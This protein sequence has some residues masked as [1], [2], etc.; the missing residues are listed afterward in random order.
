MGRA[1]E[2]GEAMERLLA[3]DPDHRPDPDQYSPSFRQAFEEVRRRVA[4]EPRVRLDVESAGRP[5]TVF[6]NGRPCGRAPARL[7]LPPGRY[8]VGGRSGPAR[9]GAVTVDLRAGVRTVRLDFGGGSLGSA[10]LPPLAPPV[11]LAP[12]SR[13][14]G[15]M[16]GATWGTGSAA[17]ILSGL[18]LWQGL[19]S[20]DAS[21]RARSLLQPDGSVPAASLAAYDAARA[22]AG[23]MERNAYLAAGGAALFAAAAGTLGWLSHASRSPAPSLAASEG[24]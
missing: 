9:A 16:G 21:A 24:P 1:R 22:S 12:L 23:R 8:R 6:V 5:A 3:I 19:A 10:P 2:A 14:P 20:R 15:W 18:A 13:P 7:L 17:L 4:R 11:A